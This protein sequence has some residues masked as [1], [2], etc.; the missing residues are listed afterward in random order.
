[1][2]ETATRMPYDHA[3]NLAGRVS[4]RIEPHVVR[5]KCAGSLRRRRK[6]VG[7]IEFVVEPKMVEV[8]LFGAEAPDLGPLKAEVLSWSRW[9]KG[10]ERMWQVTDVFGVEDATLDLYFAHPPAEWGSLLAIRTGPWQ[11]GRIAVTRLRHKGTPHRDGRVVGHPT[12][13]EEDFFRIADLN[14]PPPWERDAY[15]ETLLREE[16]S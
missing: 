10:G 5:S 4:E 8:D 2:S 9:V 15:A 1:M 16:R 14:C 12:P 13:T 7:D 6:S 3:Y 11:L